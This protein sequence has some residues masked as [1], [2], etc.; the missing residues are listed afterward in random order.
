[1][2]FDKQAW[3]VAN[4]ERK[5]AQDQKRYQENREEIQEGSF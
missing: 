4:R 2:A 1:M 5:R 3:T